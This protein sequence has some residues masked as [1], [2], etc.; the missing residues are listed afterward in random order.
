MIGVTTSGGWG[1]A[2][3]K[4]LVFAYVA[5]EFADPGNIFQIEILG[6]AIN[7]TVLGEPVYD[8]SNA[9]PRA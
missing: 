7:A 9:R 3:G 5:P 2:T 1:H 6:D 8:P 4:S